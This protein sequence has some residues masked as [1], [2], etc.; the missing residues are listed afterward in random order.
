MVTLLYIWTEPVLSPSPKRNIEKLCVSR[1]VITANVSSMKN[2]ARYII[3]TCV[4][5]DQCFGW[6][7]RQRAIA[8]TYLISLLSNRKFGI[9]MTNPCR[10]ENFLVPN[11][12]NWIVNK[13]ELDGLCAKDVYMYYD[14]AQNFRQHKMIESAD[15]NKLF[16]EDIVYFHTAQDYVAAIR[17]NRLTADMIPWL[18]RYTIGKAYG[19]I[20]RHLFT[21]NN[22]TRQTVTD[23]FYKHVKDCKLVCAHIRMGDPWSKEAKTPQSEL[24]LIWN[25]LNIYNNVSKYKIYVATDS[26]ETKAQAIKHFRYQIVDT[27]G[28]I[29]QMERSKSCDVFRRVIVEQEILTRCDVL[30]L[31]QSS[32]GIIAAFMRNTNMG[33]YCFFEKRVFPY[34]QHKPKEENNNK[35]IKTVLKENNTKKYSTNQHTIPDN[36]LI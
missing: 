2:T 36:I 26:N 22:G 17:R 21:L 19:Y 20:M 16:P 9:Y 1:S 15:F 6:G 30:M 29:D 3:D 33:L 31:T 14:E 28:I 13:N 12:V 10:L 4:D 8:T 23:V 35:S 5:Q 11:R 24:P 32:L 18:H 27:E 7:D 25:F 34:A